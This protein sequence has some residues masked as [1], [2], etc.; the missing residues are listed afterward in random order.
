MIHLVVGVPGSGKSLWTTRQIVRALRSGKYVATNVG[1][2]EDWPMRAA[3]MQ[4]IGWLRPRHARK[5]A[6]RNARNMVVSGDLDYLMSLRLPEYRGR[7]SGEGRGIVVLDEAHLWL[8]TRAFRDEDRPKLVAWFSQH[9]KLGWDVYLI[10][11]SDKSIDQQI[12]RLAEYVVKLRNLRKFRL[13]GIPITGGMNVF[14]GVWRWANESRAKPMRREMFLLN[15]KLA[16]LYDTLAIHETG[17]DELADART[18]LMPISPAGEEGERARVRRAAGAST[19]R[20]TADRRTDARSSI[21]PVGH[22]ARFD[23]R[24]GERLRCPV[25]AANPPRRRLRPVWLGG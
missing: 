12:A 4:T 1:M 20:G 18:V 13:M 22:R 15:R 5:L 8:N 7:G 16:G 9:R 2:V 17:A 23:A 3:R 10:T 6:A 19:E 21:S 11:Q 25:P 14:L 24:T